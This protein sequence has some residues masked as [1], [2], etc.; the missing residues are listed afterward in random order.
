M[1]CVKC[2]LAYMQID[3]SNKCTRD[4]CVYVC[5]VYVCICMYMYVYV[6]ILYMYHAVTRIMYS[7]ITRLYI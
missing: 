4:V 6:C 7:A 5:I 2:M 3:L 1:L